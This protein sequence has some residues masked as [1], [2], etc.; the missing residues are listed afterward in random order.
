MGG[1]FFTLHSLFTTKKDTGPFNFQSN[2]LFSQFLRQKMA[3]TK[4]LLYGFLENK[5][6]GGM[7]IHPPVPQ[8]LTKRIITSDYNS[9]EPPPKFIR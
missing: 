1:G 2:E 8:N 9:N 6:C 7:L 4:F 3:V 5:R